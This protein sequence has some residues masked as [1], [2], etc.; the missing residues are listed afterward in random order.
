MWEMG[1]GKWGW[2]VCAAC[3]YM[4]V[5]VDARHRDRRTTAG[6]SGPSM[7]DAPIAQISQM[8]ILKLLQMQG[9][10]T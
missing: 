3:E 2:S 10:L 7:P 4:K 8:L 5:E 1:N 6:K 9:S